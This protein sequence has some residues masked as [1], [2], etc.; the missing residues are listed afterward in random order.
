M[1][2]DVGKAPRDFL[3]GRDLRHPGA[4]Q[5]DAKD[6]PGQVAAAWL[7]HRVVRTL[8]T[9]GADANK[10]AACLSSEGPNSLRAKLRGDRPMSLVDLLR[11]AMAIQPS[12]LTHLPQH[13]SD[14]A[15]LLPPE[16]VRLLPDRT[17]GKYRRITFQ[18]DG[19]VRVDWPSLQLSLSDWLED[20]E[21]DSLAWSITPQVLRVELI[22]QLQA[23]G[24]GGHLLAPLAGEDNSFAVL[25]PKPEIVMALCAAPAGGS[26]EELESARAK[27]VRRVWETA[28]R[29]VQGV[30]FVVAGSPPA[31]RLV[32]DVF[33]DADLSG[34]TGWVTIGIQHAEAAGIPEASLDWPDL[35]VSNLAPSPPSQSRIATYRVDVKPARDANQ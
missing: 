21:T 12:V 19:L 9:E 27:L 34:Q 3:V 13:L 17:P 6:D 14:L 29:H 1:A 31:M 25:T 35:Y 28:M 10:M 7:Q 26:I 22:R 4:W 18:A 30:H 32:A 8:V 5:I 11:W 33:E 15:Q 16:A 24:I 20:V 23:S 2:G